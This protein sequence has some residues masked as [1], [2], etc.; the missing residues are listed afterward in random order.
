MSLIGVL[1]NI[2]FVSIELNKLSFDVNSSMPLMIS[3]EVIS[4]I[5]N[6]LIWYMANFMPKHRLD[7]IPIMN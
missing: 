5:K 4:L 6:N 1:N 7:P 3:N 2:S